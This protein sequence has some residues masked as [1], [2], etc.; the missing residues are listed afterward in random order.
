MKYKVLKE[1]V[2]P[3]GCHVPQGLLAD[4]GEFPS[5]F[6][7]ALKENGFIEEI[8]DEPWKPKEG[9]N[10]YYITADGQEGACVCMT[11]DELPYALRRNEIGNSFP[12]REERNRAREW[13]K[14]FKVLREDTKGFKSDWKNRDEVK[15]AVYYD[16]VTGGFHIRDWFDCVVHL[17]YFATEA[18]AKESIEKHSHEWKVFFGIEEIE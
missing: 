18:D 2:S 8:K 4:N 10:D 13:L 5:S 16:F 17:I 7:R 6:T 12:T 14:A 9:E 1:F 3:D 11:K 15:Y